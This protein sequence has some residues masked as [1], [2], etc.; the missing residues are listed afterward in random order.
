MQLVVC[1][2]C[3]NCF[4]TIIFAINCFYIYPKV[5]IKPVPIQKWMLLQGITSRNELIISVDW[6]WETSGRTF[7]TVD[8]DY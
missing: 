6:M 4:Y 1:V 5:W 2:W 3:T 7:S 8:K